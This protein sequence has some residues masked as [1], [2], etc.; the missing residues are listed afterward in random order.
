MTFGYVAQADAYVIVDPTVGGQPIDP[1][2]VY[3]VAKEVGGPDATEDAEILIDG[4][5]AMAELM[6]EYMQTEE[7]VI[8]P[9]TDHPGNRIV[10]LTEIPAGAVTY[11]VA[12]SEKK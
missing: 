7:C 11:T 3:L 4:M 2:A 10:P 8:L 12:K 6:A 1:E 9:D 5:E